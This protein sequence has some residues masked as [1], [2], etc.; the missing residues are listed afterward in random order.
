MRCGCKQGTLSYVPCTQAS[1][2]LSRLS[3]GTVISYKASALGNADETGTGAGWARYLPGTLPLWGTWGLRTCTGSSIAGGKVA[4][5]GVPWEWGVAACPASWIFFFPCVSFFSP[6]EVIFCIAVCDLVPS[7]P[8]KVTSR[9]RV[10]S[11]R[12]CY[13]VV[14]CYLYYWL[15]LVLVCITTLDTTRQVPSQG[16]S[17]V[18]TA[19]SKL[20]SDMPN[21]ASH[22][23]ANYYPEGLLV[24]PARACLD[25]TDGLY[26]VSEMNTPPCGLASAALCCTYQV[27]PGHAKQPWEVAVPEI[28]TVHVAAC[29]TTPTF[30][31][32]CMCFRATRLV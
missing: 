3:Q 2:V 5:H 26:T 10:D 9:K 6:N 30:S 20:P 8:C 14:T 18:A 13:L 25:T 16:S 27:Q 17:L 24:G 29:I 21:D 15:V 12:C 23:L 11:K 32:T 22:G 7:A 19:F 31:I 28:T 4:A 1:H